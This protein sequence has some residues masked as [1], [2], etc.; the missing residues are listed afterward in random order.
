MFIHSLQNL[1]EDIMTKVYA[2]QIKNLSDARYFASMEVDFLGISLHESDDIYKA[3]EL[4]SWVEGPMTVAEPRLTLALDP[5]VSFEKFDFV[6]S[7]KELDFIPVPDHKIIS[8]YSLDDQ[9]FNEDYLFILSVKQDFEKLTLQDFEKLKDILNSYNNVILSIPFDVNNT[10]E[11]IA[12][13]NPPCILVTGGEEEKTGFKSFEKL[14]I[15]FEQIGR[16]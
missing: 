9:F 15:F 7:P 5:D 14:D 13:L 3:Y 2:S 8:H 4:M 16:I 1:I 6:L 11:L 10:A 12:T